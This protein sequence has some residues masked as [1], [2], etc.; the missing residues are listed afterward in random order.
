M[1]T[2][3]LWGNRGIGDLFFYLPSINSI[4]KKKVSSKI[5]IPQPIWDIGESAGKILPEN[6]DMIPNLSQKSFLLKNRRNAHSKVEKEY[7]SSQI[8]AELLKERNIDFFIT[9]R[10]YDLRL[11]N[12]KNKFKLDKNSQEHESDKFGGG[13]EKTGV[14]YLRFDYELNYPFKKK[15][16]GKILLIQ[17]SGKREKDLSE[18]L[19]EKIQR[20]LSE[21]QVEVLPRFSEGFRYD[22]FISMG[23]NLSEYSL[24]VGPDT[25]L[26]HYADA[27]GVLCIGI[28]NQSNIERYGPK[29][30]L[31]LC[32]NIEGENMEKLDLKK[33]Y[34][35]AKGELD[36]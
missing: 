26:L 17:E 2:Y 15:K 4:V 30:S 21:Y 9:T 29:N 23:Q 1:E 10:D 6:V 22:D 8:A 28:F 5:L 32:L 33:I 27:L 13:I 11:F 19:M 14:P 25:G 12:S 16:N 31:E 24:I 35:R 3:C 36:G 7:W 34:E 18:S 20:A